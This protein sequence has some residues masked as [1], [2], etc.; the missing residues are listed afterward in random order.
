MAKREEPW[1]RE[2]RREKER[3]VRE[4]GNTGV[5]RGGGLDREGENGEG[6]RGTKIAGHSV[7]L[8]L[9][10]YSRRGIKGRQWG[11]KTAFVRR[12][13]CRSRLE[14]RFNYEIL[15]NHPATL[16]GWLVHPLYLLR[17]DARRALAASTTKRGSGGWE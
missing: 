1:G 17:H 3:M 4:G 14:K 11:R 7:K 5:R 9:C 8:A 16:A 13:S 10:S 2:G 6:T 12:V 15:R